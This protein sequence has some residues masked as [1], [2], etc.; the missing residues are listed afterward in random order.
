MTVIVGGCDVGSAT[1]KALIMRDGKIAAYAIIPATTKPDKTA[2]KVMDEALSKVGLSSLREIEYVVGTGYGRAK[3]PFANQNISEITCHAKAAYW[4]RPTV[5]TVIDIGGQDCKVIGIDDRG[6]VRDFTMNDKCAAGTGRFFE[7]MARTLEVELHELSSL[8]LRSQKPAQ[9][10]SQCS[11]FA[12]SEVIS[13][14]SDGVDP[15]DIAAGLLVSVAGRLSS[16]VRSIGIVKDVTVSGGCAKNRGLVESLQKKLG[17][18]IEILPEDPQIIGALG[19]ALI[20]REK[21][22][23]RT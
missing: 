10:T 8:A 6:K 15:A 20:A 13:L 22:D 1:G 2:Y 23:A 19:A 11:V 4:L 14:V 7:A 18:S 17:T 21:L 9:I 5:R 16:L 3:V 12:E